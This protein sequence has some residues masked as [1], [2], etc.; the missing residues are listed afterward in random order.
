L[1]TE[2]PDKMYQPGTDRDTQTR[3]DNAQQSAFAQ[4][5][6]DQPAAAGAQC[7][8]YGKLAL[9]PGRPGQKQACDIHACTGALFRQHGTEILRDLVVRHMNRLNRRHVSMIEALVSTV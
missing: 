1:R 7:C 2:C 6:A 3:P 4:E 9:S 5:L 8:S